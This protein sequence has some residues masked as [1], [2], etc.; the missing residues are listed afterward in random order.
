MP[1]HVQKRGISHDRIDASRMRSVQFGDVTA[2]IGRVSPRVRAAQTGSRIEGKI[3]PAR[4]ILT[5]L[6]SRFAAHSVLSA[7]VLVLRSTLGE[8]L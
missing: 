8:V 7:L 3:Y 2:M 6:P 1:R 4:E 5:R